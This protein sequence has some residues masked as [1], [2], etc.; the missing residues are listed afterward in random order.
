MRSHL[1]HYGALDRADVGDDRSGRQVRADF[2][3]DC[4]AGADRNADDDEIGARDRG[5]IAFDH[6]IGE[7]KF[8]DAPAGCGRLRGGHDLAHGVL[9]T[10]GASDRR[11]D[12]A[13]RRS[14]RGD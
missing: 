10:R 1:A 5:G 3:G 9:G 13:R 6:L 4:A 14:A 11:A 7:A 12:Q 8:G 2:G